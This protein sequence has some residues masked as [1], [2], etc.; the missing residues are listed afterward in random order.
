MSDQSDGLKPRP[1]SI[2]LWP[3]RVY[4]SVEAWETG[5][6][7]DEANPMLRV[8][9]DDAVD[10]SK[11]AYLGTLQAADK[12]HQTLLLTLALL[13]LLLANPLGTAERPVVAIVLLFVAVGLLLKVRFPFD[14]PVGFDWDTTARAIE[15]D[16]MGQNWRAKC[17]N[18]RSS[19]HYL[20]QK[21][22]SFHHS[23]AIA[24]IGAALLAWAW[25]SF[26]GV[27]P[28]E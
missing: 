19:R 13:S 25:T 7:V 3:F 16:K 22:I 27:N 8:F 6:V 14:K 26:F 18:H 17:A 10:L 1:R 12:C 9:A 4:P 15:T 24:L 20:I 28:W 11:T 21:A 2:A 23:A 5:P